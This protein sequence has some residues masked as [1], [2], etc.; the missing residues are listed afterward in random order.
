[1]GHRE[2]IKL[3]LLA[4]VA[5]CIELQLTGGARLPFS[6]RDRL[7][8]MGF[9]RTARESVHHFVY[10]RRTN[11]SW[12][13]L[14]SKRAPLVLSSLKTLIEAYPN[15]IALDEAVEHLAGLFAEFINDSEFDLSEEPPAMARKELRSWLKNG[16]I[17]ERDGLVMATNAFQRAIA[18]LESLESETMTST[19]SRL[20]TVQRAIELLDAQLSRNQ[21]EREKSLQTRID[22]LQKELKAVQAGEFEVLDGPK[23]IEGIREVYQ[24]A[25]SLQS[26]FRRVEDSYRKADRELRERVI[27]EKQNRGEIVDE[28]LNGYDALVNTAEGQVFETFH[29]Q[30]VKTAELE[31]MKARL[32]SI[33]DNSNTDE[34]LHRKQR[35]DLQQ[36]VSRLVQESERVI[37]ARARSERDVRTFLK[38]GLVDEQIRVGSLLQ[39]ILQAALKVDWHSA[40]VRK[41]DSPL[42]PIAP[43]LSNLPIVER[44]LAKQAEQTEGEDLELTFREANPDE[45]DDEFW[46]AYHALNRAQLFENTLNHLLQAGTPLS[47]GAL[48][49]AL[50][51][52]H[53]LETLA[54]WLAMARQ[55]GVE[56][57]EETEAI[58]LQD[59]SVGIIRFTVP[60]MKLSSDHVQDLGASSLE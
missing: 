29:A 41:T 28:L 36:L 11:P 51:P 45:M 25:V 12:Q 21:F 39:E 5:G 31:E 15:G 50:P 47:I 8:D 44:L 7:N 23:A 19:A 38:S 43:V 1:M 33:L 49:K 54:Y 6:I 42:P 26:D 18:F 10:L 16:L 14:T 52:T 24:L 48:A 56:V 17:V 46:Q 27:S 20:A 40:K 13:L 9:G 59:D 4:Y 57:P 3:R 60:D 35:A 22:A 32:R 55:A 58:D 30:L 53:D 2:R 34:A 37:Q